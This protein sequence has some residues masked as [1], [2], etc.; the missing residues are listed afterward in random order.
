MEEVS[1]QYWRA[2]GAAPTQGGPGA[3]LTMLKVVILDIVR[4]EL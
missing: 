1:R 2:R 3:F 4:G